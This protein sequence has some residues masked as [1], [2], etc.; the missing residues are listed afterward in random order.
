L[1][2]RDLS[3]SGGIFH[4]RLS[5]SSSNS[6][7]DD[8]TATLAPSGGDNLAET[9]EPTEV[10]DINDDNGQDGQAEDLNDDNGQDSQSPS[11]DDGQSQH[12]SGSDSSGSDSSGSDSSGS[13]S[14][15]DDGGHSGGGDDSGGGH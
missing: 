14:G 4:S 9:P 8:P 12:N 2:K 1:I 13:G 10:E 11:M 15:S 5:L 7:A 6:A 3:G